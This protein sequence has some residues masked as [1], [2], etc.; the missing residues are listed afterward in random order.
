MIKN[1]NKMIKI[2][3]RS[4]NVQNNKMQKIAKNQLKVIIVREKKEKED[5][6]LDILGIYRWTFL[7]RLLRIIPIRKITP[8]R[9]QRN[10]FNR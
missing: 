4:S 10:L 2:T 3:E 7:R 9:N 6:T 1:N 8:E 5:M